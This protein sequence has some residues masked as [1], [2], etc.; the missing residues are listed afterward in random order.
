[1]PSIE[2]RGIK[3]FVLK[4][5]NLKVGNGEL[6]CV[7]GPNGAGKT[8]LLK[9]IAGLVR[10]EGNVLFDG[11]PVDSE[12]PERRGVGYV[13]Q[14]LALFPH[15]TVEENIAYGLRVR[16]LP[17]GVVERRVNELI[18]LLELNGLRGRYPKTLSGGEK[19]RVAIARALAIEPRI[20]LLDEPFSNIQSS[21]KHQLISEIRKLQSRLH[22][23]TI[24]V[25][26]DISEAEEL[27]SRIAVL[28]NG[29]LIGVG[30]LREVIGVISG[31]LQE[32]N[33]M[34][35]V[36]S[37][38]GYDG[39]TRV[40]CGEL[41]LTV[42]TEKPLK[43][44][45]EVLVTI[46]PNKVVLLKEPQ[47]AKVNMFKASVVRSESE[48]SLI[49]VSLGDLELKVTVPDSFN[50]NAGGS[51]YVKLPIKYLRIVV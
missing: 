42:P 4:G 45:D 38:S 18:K 8:T 35:C 3:N 2:L 9:V 44:G 22:I 47:Y 30:E 5:I 12:P 10:Y 6:L 19:Q 13:P 39:I 17:K 25:T 27:S 34:R 31:V 50:L 43:V 20:L 48:R 26:H 16:G 7:L 29:S 32:L 15:M 11:V 40:K 14:N 41:T 21:V 24:F 51:V 37:A 46:P 36:I 1:M 49:T 28:N 23:T 33:V